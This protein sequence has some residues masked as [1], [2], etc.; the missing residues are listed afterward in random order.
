MQ[1]KLVDVLPLAAA[2]AMFAGLVSWEH[3]HPR[4]SPPMAL[5]GAKGQNNGFALP[6]NAVTNVPLTGTVF[7]SSG[8][9]FLA[10]NQLN[11]LNTPC[12]TRVTAAFTFPNVGA[13]T[14]FS[15][16]INVNGGQVAAWTFS[17]PANIGPISTNLGDLFSLPANAVV[18]VSMFQNSGAAINVNVTLS[19]EL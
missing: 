10:G 6:N 13:V 17:V 7:D 15:V 16:F 9:V 2:V 4:R 14:T 11:G 19:M 5:T 12:L 18:Q 1:R 3:D 8:G